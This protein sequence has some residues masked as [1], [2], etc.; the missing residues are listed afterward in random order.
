MQTLKDRVE[1]AL[2]QRG[3]TRHSGRF[4]A[5]DKLIARMI[6][7]KKITI[8]EKDE[9]LRIAYEWVGK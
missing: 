7:G 1:S 4:L 6:L 8:E 2:K 9:A 5:V 3:I